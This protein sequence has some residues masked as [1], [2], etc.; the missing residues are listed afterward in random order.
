[1]KSLGDYM[2]NLREIEDYIR[3]AGLLGGWESFKEVY[4][5]ET[6]NDFVALSEELI[7]FLGEGFLTGSLR[8]AL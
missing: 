1:M 2:E 6:V 3:E 7:A 4:P 8:E 5:R